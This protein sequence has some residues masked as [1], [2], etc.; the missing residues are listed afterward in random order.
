M[1]YD[2]PD[3]LGP[4]S[5]FTI[6]QF[7]EALKERRGSMLYRSP[8]R[9]AKIIV[10]SVKK[11]ENGKTYTTDK[12]SERRTPPKGYPKNVKMYLDA[13]NLKYPIDT[14]KHIRAALSYFSQYQGSYPPEKRKKMWRKLIKRAKHFGIEISPELEEK[15]DSE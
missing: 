8:I 14:E 6:E 11:K 9:K 15:Y 7:K 3:F 4:V 10:K 1:Q 5:E 13:A 12:E 2:R